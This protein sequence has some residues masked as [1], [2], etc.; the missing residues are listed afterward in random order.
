MGD[1]KK[2]LRA[3]SAIVVVGEKRAGFW[4]EE[5]GQSSGG[6]SWGRVLVVGAEAG[7]W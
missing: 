2:R 6:R 7:F 5:M 1:A 4:W 3:A